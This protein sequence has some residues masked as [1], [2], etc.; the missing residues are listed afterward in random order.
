M[1]QDMGARG[2][3]H[4]PLEGLRWPS[5]MIFPSFTISTWYLV[6]IATQ[7]SSHSCRME[8]RNPD[9]SLS[10]MCLICA[11]WDSL[12]ERGIVA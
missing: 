1:S 9:L 7:S 2:I 5:M 3:L 12:V 10:N 4:R 6:N 11:S 8:I